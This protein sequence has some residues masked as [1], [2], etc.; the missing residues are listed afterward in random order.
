MKQIVEEALFDSVLTLVEVLDDLRDGEL[1]VVDRGD[2]GLASLGEA[3]DVGHSP[4]QKRRRLILK[5]NI[6][7]KGR[8]NHLIDRLSFTLGFQLELFLVT[9]SV[10]CRGPTIRVI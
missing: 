2:R 10:H 3:G 4:R 9:Q 6:G 8:V 1:G 7:D 5:L